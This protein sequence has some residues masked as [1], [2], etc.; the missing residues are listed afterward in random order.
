MVKISEKL[1]GIHNFIKNDTTGN[2]KQIAD[3]L[4]ALGSAA[5]RGGINSR[6]WERYIL[7]LSTSPDENEEVIEFDQKQISRLIGEDEEFNRSEWGS[8]AL[9]YI[10]ANSTCGIA[11][12]LE[13]G[14][15]M[16][17]SAKEALDFFSE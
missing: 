2:G 13:T 3:K 4:Q 10:P 14:R 6:D 11:T 8:I 9:A 17:T 1:D 7:E 16:P 12:T 5:I 15:N